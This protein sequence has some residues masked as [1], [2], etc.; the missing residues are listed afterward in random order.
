[1]SL[2]K[3]QNKLYLHIAHI[4]QSKCIA[5]TVLKKSPRNG[6]YVCITIKL[7]NGYIKHIVNCPKTDIM[8]NINL[9]KIEKITLTVQLEVTSLAKNTELFNIMFT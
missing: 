1:M 3:L 7:Y 8:Y 5:W 6:I 2:R 9:Y 4:E